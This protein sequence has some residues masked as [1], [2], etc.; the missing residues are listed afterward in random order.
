MDEWIFSYLNKG[1]KKKNLPRFVWRGRKREGREM[2]ERG[3]A[4]RHQRKTPRKG[5]RWG[6]GGGGGGS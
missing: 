2:K 3:N 5:K 4:A 6:G 1:Y